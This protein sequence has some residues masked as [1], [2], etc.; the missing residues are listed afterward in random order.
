[1]ELHGGHGNR[2]R[3]VVDEHLEGG[4]GLHASFLHQAAFTGFGT[5]RANATLNALKSIQ[6]DRTVV[7]RPDLGPRLTPLIFE[8]ET[9]INEPLGVIRPSDDRT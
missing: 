3:R 6:S 4:D 9:A 5:E 1:M 2:D 7:E 8:L